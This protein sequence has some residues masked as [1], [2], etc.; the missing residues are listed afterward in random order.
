MAR[1]GR[2][3]RGTGARSPSARSARGRGRSQGAAAYHRDRSRTPAP[4][5]PSPPALKRRPAKKR[6]SEAD[7]APMKR[8]AETPPISSKRGGKVALSLS[9]ACH[10]HLRLS[11]PS[12]R[13]NDA[14][15]TSSIPRASKTSTQVC[16]CEACWKLGILDTADGLAVLDSAPL[17]FMGSFVGVISSVYPAC[18]SSWR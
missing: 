9:P 1:Y 12:S 17:I 10:D 2:R 15:G 4:R 7:V 13:R 14:K 8:P 18:A 5:Q 16:L 3:G 6:K 11:Y